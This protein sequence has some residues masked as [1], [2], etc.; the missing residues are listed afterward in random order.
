V[1]DGT[2]ALNASG[3][4]ACDGGIR[5]AAENRRGGSMRNLRLNIPQL[6]LVGATRGMIGAGAGLL[7]ADRM[8]RDRRKTIGWA[9]LA[10]GALSTI[11]IALIT[12]RR[13]DKDSRR[14]TMAD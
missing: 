2:R 12:L 13:S 11:P 5:R 1:D 14:A 10:V 9:L 8:R 7:I 3:I 4:L 6:V